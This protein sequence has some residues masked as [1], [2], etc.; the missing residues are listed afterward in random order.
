[1]NGKNDHSPGSLSGEGSSSRL[2]FHSPKSHAI[3]DPVSRSYR[4]LAK[5]DPSGGQ[6]MSRHIMNAGFLA[7]CTLF[8]VGCASNHS[9]TAQ[10]ASQELNLKVGST[11]RFFLVSNR[12]TG[13]QWDIDT[14][15][16]AGMEHVTIAKSGY[17]KTDAADGVVGAPGR[18]WWAIRGTSPGKTRLKLD[19]Q[20]PWETDV[21][22]ARQASVLIEVVN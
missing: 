17:T 16:S 11:H 10:V 20:R 15:A 8:C 14:D 2:E 9:G 22:P 4:I 18:Q 7:F 1:M 3:G 12:T 13:F 6:L 19:Y 21:P 5:F